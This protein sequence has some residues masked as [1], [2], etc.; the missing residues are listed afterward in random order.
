M[1]SAGPHEPPPEYRDACRALSVGARARRND[2]RVRHAC[3]PAF[4]TRNNQERGQR[5]ATGRFLIQRGAGAAA[6]RRR[7]QRDSSS[8]NNRLLAPQPPNSN[9]SQTC[10]VRPC[11]NHVLFFFAEL[12]HT[13]LNPVANAR[14][15]VAHHTLL[16]RTA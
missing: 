5:D 15:L 16:L 4:K 7:P 3:L 11:F 13:S 2:N 12:L 10:R 8:K 14:R 9:K 1:T 6:S